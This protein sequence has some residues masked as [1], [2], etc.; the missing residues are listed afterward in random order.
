MV[1]FG[2]GA[3]PEKGA[4]PGAGPGPKAKAKVGGAA[5]TGAG[6]EAGVETLRGEGGEEKEA[7]G[8]EEGLIMKVQLT[9]MCIKTTHRKL[10][11]L[12]KTKSV[13]VP[14]LSD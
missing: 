3:L 7:R 13:R 9:K 11:N 6:P 1:G 5:G 14:C 12:Q 2:A 4:G 8:G 10:V